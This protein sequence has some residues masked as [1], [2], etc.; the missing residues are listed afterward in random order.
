MQ[1]VGVLKIEQNQTN[2]LKNDIVTYYDRGDKCYEKK[3]NGI[4]VR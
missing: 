2:V 1:K 4:Q 3:K